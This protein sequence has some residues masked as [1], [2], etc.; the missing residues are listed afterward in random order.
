MTKK[1]FR[2]W[3]LLGGIFI[4]PL[5]F[6]STKMLPWSGENRGAMAIQELTY[7]FAWLWHNSIKGVSRTWQRYVTLQDAERENEHL[8]AEMEGLRVKLLDHEEKTV[9]LNRLRKLAG[10]TEKLED[11]Y[12]VA[13]VVMGQRNSPFKT[14]RI[15]KGSLDGIAPGMPVITSEG[16]VGRTIRV[17]AKMSDVQ[18]VVDYDSN[19]DILVQR[20]RIRGVLSGFATEDCRLHLQRG[21]E[22]KI[23]DTLITSGIVGSFP[24]GL[25][26]GKVVKISFETD[27][28]S[29]V[30]TVEPWVDHKR[31]EEVIVLL[32]TDPDLERIVQT[33]GPEWLENSTSIQTSAGG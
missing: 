25:P 9:E 2:F 12:T 6:F 11:Q 29:Q 24:K 30:V 4:A 19:I 14:I 23:G 7:P 28:V 8:K 31:L 15:S 10:F 21:T 27:N 18:L 17:G 16:V 33:A 20:N 1:R 3:F 13:E 32:R 22:V 5:A 26:V